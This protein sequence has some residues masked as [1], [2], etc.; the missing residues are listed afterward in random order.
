[1]TFA[2][3]IGIL[4]AI[5]LTVL[6]YIKVLPA[7][8]DGTFR[9]RIAQFLHDYFNFK[10]LYLEVVLKAVFA[11]ASISC[12]TI[13]LLG[14][15]IGSIIELVKNVEIAIDYG[16]FGSW[17]WGQFFGNFFGGI[18][19]AVF[20]PIVLR[21]VYELVL[22]L[23]LLCKNV[24]EI[25][26]KLKTEESENVEAEAETFEEAP[27]EEEAEIIPEAAEEAPAVIE[28]A[29]EIIEEA[30][31]AEE[32]IPAAEEAPAEEETETPAE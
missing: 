4:A 11:F 9:K 21:L 16:Y 3:V 1:M 19:L 12:V 23:V 6:L 29:P 10:K 17:V 32:E 14:A 22:M 8:L 20:G 27:V 28:E 18:A 24:A 7:K 15:T 30:P 2:T 26:K 31:A 13:G 25:N 5:A